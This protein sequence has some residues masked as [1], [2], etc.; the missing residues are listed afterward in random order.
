MNREGRERVAGEDGFVALNPKVDKERLD[1]PLH[2]E[3]SYLQKDYSG[4]RLFAIVPENHSFKSS[5]RRIDRKFKET[6]GIFKT[7]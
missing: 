3:G 7:I 4:Y 1:L 6:R 2:E 5:S